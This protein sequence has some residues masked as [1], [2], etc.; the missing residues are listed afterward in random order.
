MKYSAGN[1]L[2]LKDGRTVYVMHVNT[3]TKKY[4]VFDTENE[5][6]VFDITESDILMKLS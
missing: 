1:I 3:T 6:D 2:A 5:N 4:Q